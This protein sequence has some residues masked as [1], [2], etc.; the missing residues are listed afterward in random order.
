[1]HIYKTVIVFSKFSL[2][3]WRNKTGTYFHDWFGWYM[4]E[5]SN[6]HYMFLKIISMIV[7]DQMLASPPYQIHIL[8]P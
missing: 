2:I 5:S 8:K 7:I 6:T 4:I 3:Q 1:M